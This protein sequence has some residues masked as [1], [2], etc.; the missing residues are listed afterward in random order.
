MSCTLQT[1]HVV[2]HLLPLTHLHY[3]HLRKVPSTDVTLQASSRFSSAGTS[4]SSK[5]TENS[6]ELLSLSTRWTAAFLDIS[7]AF[8]K[9]LHEGFLYKT[10]AIFPDSIDK[11]LQSYL[12][13]LYFLVKYRETYTSLRP[14]SSGGPTGQRSRP[15]PLPPVC[16]RLT[17]YGWHRNCYLC[18][19]HSRP[20]RPCRS[21]NCY[22]Q[23]TSCS[24]WNSTMA[25]K[26]RMKANEKKPTH[27]IFTL[28]RSPCP[29]VQLNSTYLVQ[30]ADVKYLGIHLDRR[31]TWRNHIT[32]KKNSWTSNYENCTGALAENRNCHWKI[33]CSC[34]KR[35]WNPYGPTVYSCGERRQTPISISW[36]DFSPNS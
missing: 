20:R 5:P 30:P 2:C 25:Q 21:S 13:N 19:W 3:H 7:Q 27:V 24:A 8:D 34:I 9:V 35:S 18:R 17:S 33:N 23:T 10:K 32:T 12:Q 28:K 22:A 6:V 11:I 4:T 26:W 1:V 31:L 15:A 29:F 16:S 14:V 36:K